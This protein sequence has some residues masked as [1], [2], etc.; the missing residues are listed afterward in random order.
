LG[1]AARWGVSSLVKVLSWRG[2]G[3]NWR[4]ERPR[5][6]N[7]REGAWCSEERRQKG[8]GGKKKKADNEELKGVLKCFPT[9]Y[10]AGE[11]KDQAEGNDA[12]G[13]EGWESRAAKTKA[14]VW[15]APNN[16]KKR[17]YRERVSSKKLIRWEGG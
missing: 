10:S 14:S 17:G 8:G 5:T 3:K 12:N 1:L 2:G 7:R 13:G 9:T 16:L 11:K 6:K 4:R 15:V